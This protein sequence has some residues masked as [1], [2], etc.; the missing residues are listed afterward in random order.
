PVTPP[1]DPTPPTTPTDPAPTTNLIANAS[2][3]TAN[4]TDPTSWNRGGWGTNTST[5]TYVSGSAHT[6]SRSAQVKTTSYTSGD[7]K[8]YASPVAVT[9]GTTYTYQDYYTATVATPV[10]VAMTNTSGVDSY[11]NLTNAPAATGWMLYTSN[12]TVPSGIKNVVI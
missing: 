12:F 2:F 10:V 1:T 7:V 9:A 5:L 4:G 6:G 3:E 11:V 8:W